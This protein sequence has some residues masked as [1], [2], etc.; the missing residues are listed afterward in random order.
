[1]FFHRQRIQLI[2][3]SEIHIQ[4]IPSM[5]VCT[6]SVHTYVMQNSYM[7][8]IAVIWLSS[9]MCVCRQ[10]RWC[11]YRLIL[12]ISDEGLHPSRR[13]CVSGEVQ[14]CK[15]SITACPHRNLY[16][17]IWLLLYCTPC[18]IIISDPLLALLFIL[19]LWLE[20][21]F[22]CLLI[23]FS[24]CLCATALQCH[25]EVH[26][27][28]SPAAQCTHAQPHCER[29]Q[30]DGLSPGILPWLAGRACSLNIALD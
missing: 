10:W 5:Y 26:Q 2:D 20:D 19:W 13:Q 17:S 23:Y 29:A 14:H 6:A 11:W 24:W 4:Y 22:L 8:H 28:A 16:Q 12:W 9:H 15:S 25:Y 3:Y 21:V 30:L 27:S 7:S 1:M 18:C